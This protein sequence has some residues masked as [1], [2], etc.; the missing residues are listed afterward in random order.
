MVDGE[1]TGTDVALVVLFPTR[2]NPRIALLPAVRHAVKTEDISYLYELS[3][4]FGCT[5]GYQIA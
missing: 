1:F 3:L 4:V 5:I 2:W